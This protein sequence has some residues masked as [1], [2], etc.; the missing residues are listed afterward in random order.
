MEYPALVCAL[1][2]G[3]FLSL[4]SVA[5]FPYA[6]HN[7]S[8]QEHYHR[9]WNILRVFWIGR[10]HHQHYS[11]LIAC[12]I[13][14]FKFKQFQIKQDQNVHRVGTDG[15]LLGAGQ[16]QSTQ[17]YSWYWHGHGCNC[18]DVGTTNWCW[19]S[20][21]IEP[22]REAFSPPKILNRA[23]FIKGS[24]LFIHHFKV[25]ILERIWFD[26]LQPS[27]FENGLNRQPPTDNNKGIP[28]HFRKLNCWS[29]Q[30]RL[31][32]PRENWPLCCHPQSN[33]FMEH[34]L[35]SNLFVDRACAVYSKVGKTS[36]T[37]AAAILRIMS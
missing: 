32:A 31:L 10:R 33:R 14:I 24:K 37:L 30:R 16:A 5:A 4:A 15:V 8:S 1:V 9:H 22:D 7:L 26:C 11:A 13:D 6:L 3:V 20:P 23:P 29:M 25:L 35:M 34:A 21:A 28:I 36:G 18:P 19:K 2:A 17:R 27:I 12:A